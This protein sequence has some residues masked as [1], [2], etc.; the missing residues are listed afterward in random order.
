MNEFG[1]R[2]KDLEDVNRVTSLLGIEAKRLG[3]PEDVLAKL[4]DV[5]RWTNDARKEMASE[6]KKSA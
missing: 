6:P 2:V 5:I 4:R 3:A 1:K